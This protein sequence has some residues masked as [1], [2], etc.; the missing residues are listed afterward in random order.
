MLDSAAMEP[1]SPRRPGLFITF[2][3]DDG[4]GKS[5]QMEALAARL[6][7]HGQATRLTGEPQGTPLG[8]ALDRLLKDPAN[9][10]APRA[11]ALLFLAARAQHVDTVIRPAVAAGEWVLCSRFSHSTWAYQCGGLGLAEAP[12]RAADAFARDGLLPDLVLVFDAHPEEA[13]QRRAGRAPAD[14]IEGRGASYHERVVDAFRR[15]AADDPARVRLVDAR[16]SVE[17]VAERVWALVRERL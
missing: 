3:G 4:V 11:E 5:T 17:A 8:A 14:R 2:E 7:A 12:V 16:G 13:A 6:Q 9:Q 10:I 15:Y 1:T